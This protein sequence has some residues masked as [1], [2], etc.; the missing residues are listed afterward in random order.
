M[1]FGVRRLDIKGVKKYNTMVAEK[2]LRILRYGSEM[3]KMK[4]KMFALSKIIVFGLI[5]GFAAIVPGLSGGAIAVSLG[6]YPVLIRSVLNLRKE[7]KKSIAFL[8]PFGISALLGIF[9]FGVL[10]KPLL[11]SFER[12]IIWLFMG[13]ILG[14]MPSFLKE[15]NQKG[16]KITFLIPMLIAFGA[17]LALSVFTGYQLPVAATSP[18]MLFAGGGV[19]AIGSLV[20][21]ISSS[22]IMMQMGIYEEV[23]DA[24]VTF[25]FTSMLWVALGAVVFFLLT[26]K[27]VNLAF[28]KFHGYAHFAAFG[29]LLSSMIGVFPGLRHFT[30][31]LLF[32]LGAG[33]LYGFQ[34]FLDSGSRESAK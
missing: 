19:L 12:S 30:D 9:L 10:M 15:A 27:L 3:A 18:V 31:I 26:V 16:F 32:L 14:S 21:G 2:V 22:F 25:R 34:R 20:P 6:I 4:S 8:I 13:L 7:F 29:F 17:G 11:E 24:F 23:I 1:K 5:I 33:A 28:E